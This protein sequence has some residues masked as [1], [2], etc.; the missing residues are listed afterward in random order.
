MLRHLDGPPAP[1]L[2]AL[3]DGQPELSVR[4]RALWRAYGAGQ[5]FFDVWVQDE[6]R[7]CLARLDDTFFL[8]DGGADYEEI[9]SFLHMAPY[10]TALIA[11]DRAARSVADRLPAP[12]AISGRHLLGRRAPVRKRRP[13]GG[14]IDHRPDLRSVYAVASSHFAVPGGFAPW[15]TD[16]SHRIRHGCARAYLMRAGGKPVSVCLV[17]AQSGQAGLISSVVTL[18]DYRRRGYAGALLASACADLIA[19]GRMP[20]LECREELLPFYRGLGFAEVC[21]VAELRVIE[22]GA[23]AVSI[24]PN[25]AP[26]FPAEKPERW[27]TNL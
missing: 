2:V 11:A 18:P 22:N 12:V 20:A 14:T 17:S 13:A 7:A 27:E 25:A 23:A 3:L 10:F 24:S 26:G 1:E 4:I 9:A 16:M 6:A 15:Y 5:N 8:V 21:L 19:D